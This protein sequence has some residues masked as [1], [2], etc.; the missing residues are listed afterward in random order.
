[1]LDGEDAEKLVAGFDEVKLGLLALIPPSTQE[2]ARW[3]D[4]LIRERIEKFHE[5]TF[6]RH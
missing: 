6:Q 5:S 4:E 1:V 2:T 3:F